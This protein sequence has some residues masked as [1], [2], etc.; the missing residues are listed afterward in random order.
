M[1]VSVFSVG[2]APLSTAFTV[3]LVPVIAVLA[4]AVVYWVIKG[5]DGMVPITTPVAVGMAQNER[6]A[7]RPDDALAE[8][9]TAIEMFRSSSREP[10]GH[11]VAASR[12]SSAVRCTPGCVRIERFTRIMMRRRAAES[13]TG[14]TVTPAGSASAPR[15]GSTVIP[16]DWAT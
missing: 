16:T 4:L 13:S 1:D 15:R 3:L 6:R 2:F 7:A 12:S 8:A 10:L 9:T 5:T 11:R 14:S